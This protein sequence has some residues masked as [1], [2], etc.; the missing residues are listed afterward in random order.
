MSQENS[1]DREYREWLE[2]R[3]AVTLAIFSGT[4]GVLARVLELE[5]KVRWA[6]KALDRA[7][8]ELST[9]SRELLELEGELAR[10]GYRLDGKGRLKAIPAPPA[11]TS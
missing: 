8:P 2:G 7:Q 3:D 10:R 6:R 5:D 1:V 11:P 4:T 9:A